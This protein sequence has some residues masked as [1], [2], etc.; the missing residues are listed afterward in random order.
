V[1]IDIISTGCPEPAPAP[2]IEDKNKNKSE[3]NLKIL[4]EQLPVLLVNFNEQELEIWCNMLSTCENPALEFADLLT[5]HQDSRGPDK[6]QQVIRMHEAIALFL[7][8]IT[9]SGTKNLSGQEQEVLRKFVD[10]LENSKC[11][12][13]KRGSAQYSLKQLMLYAEIEQA[14]LANKLVTFSSDHNI[15]R[16]SDGKQAVT[17]EQ[18][19]KGLAGNHAYAA[20]QC[21]DEKALLGCVIRNPWGNYGRDYNYDQKKIAAK[22]GESGEFWLELNDVCKRFREIAIIDAPIK[23]EADSKYIQ[24]SSPVG[25]FGKRVSPEPASEAVAALEPKI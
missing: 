13:G 10:F 3:E 18:K 12:P 14:L 17:G 2:A 24:S 6:P 23:Q 20:L 5:A 9:N 21:S 8:I 7:Q 15:G 4:T 1:I 19:S 11:F 22:E 16:E 25:L